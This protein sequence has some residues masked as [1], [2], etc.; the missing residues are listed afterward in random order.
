MQNERNSQEKRVLA[1]KIFLETALVDV[2]LK[3]TIGA[4]IAI[5]NAEREEPFYTINQITSNIRFLPVLALIAKR[6]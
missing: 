6:Q 1:A 2:S 4:E 5:Q 3:N